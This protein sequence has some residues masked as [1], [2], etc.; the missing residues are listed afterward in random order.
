M[1]ES[2]LTFAAISNHEGQYSIWP[3][4]LATPPGWSVEGAPGTRDAILDYIERSWRDM[5][6]KTL[7]D[8]MAIDSM[9]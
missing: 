5:R 1:H 2:D 4:T 8:A 9:K 7:R 3:A 6:P